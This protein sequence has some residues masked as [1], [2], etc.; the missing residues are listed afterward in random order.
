M[1]RKHKRG[2]VWGGEISGYMSVRYTLYAPLLN[3]NYPA[4]F[5]K[6]I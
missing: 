1:G 4:T 5:Y 6:N 2:M 3:I